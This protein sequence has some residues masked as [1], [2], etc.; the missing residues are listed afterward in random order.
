M[1]SS[2]V[3]L[4]RW[5]Y[6]LPSYRVA[7]VIQRMRARQASYGFVYLPTLPSW[8]AVRLRAPN[9][10][11]FNDHFLGEEMYVCISSHS[12]GRRSCGWANVPP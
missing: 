3:P 6:T 4:V 8:E 11:P 5:L 7:S 10:E 2:Y 1:L 9:S 12:V